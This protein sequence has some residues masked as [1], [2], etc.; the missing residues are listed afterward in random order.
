MA[1]KGFVI[2]VVGAGA[3]GSGIAQVAAANGHRVILGDANDTAVANARA[4][5]ARAIAR[6][7]EK[8]RLDSAAADA[9][10]ARIAD[11]GSLATSYASYAECDFVIEAVLEDLAV[12]RALFAGLEQVVRDDCILATNTSS[13]SVAAIGG[14]CARPERV[15][16]VHFFNPAALMPLVEIVPSIITSAPIAERCRSLVAGW[17][18]VPVMATDTP[19]FIVNRI[20]RPFYGES[21]RQLEEHIADAATIDWAMKEFG[22]FRMGPFELMD[23]IGNDV[24]F[25]VTVSVFESFFQDPRYRPALTQ[26][27]LVE[28]G[29]FGRKKGRGYY[30]YA[31]NATRPEPTRDTVLGQAILDRTLAMLVNEAVDAVYLRVASPADIELAMTKGVNY[32]KGLLAWGDEIGAATVLARLVSLH[33]EYGEDRYRPSPLLRRCVREGTP[34]LSL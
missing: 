11:A 12:K 29:L 4:T 13:L 15:A 1:G 23:F 20:A 32:P 26:R 6:D 31:E 9:V 30:D 22:G 16:G 27:R 28:A 17:N 33:A 2:G 10:T 5:I 18:K 3:M 8:G 7:V 19:G 25:A 21:L 34:L 24:N 14:G